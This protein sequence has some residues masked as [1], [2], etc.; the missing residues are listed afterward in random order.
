VEVD[1]RYRT[2]VVEQAKDDLIYVQGT[3]TLGSAPLAVEYDM[4]SLRF[5]GASSTDDASSRIQMM[6]A[7]L[8]VMDRRDAVPLFLEMLES[9]YFYARWQV[10]RELLALDATA[11]LPHLRIMA[12]DDP[13]PE[14]REAATR[15]LAHF[16]PEPSRS[17][18]E[19]LCPA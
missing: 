14:V 8:R 7:L 4:A 10:M 13:H 19:I 16:F 1:G 18:E 12:A 3:T 6:L 9:E 17:E 11:A 15:T 5:V 2:F